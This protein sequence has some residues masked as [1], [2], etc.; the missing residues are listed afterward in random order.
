[1]IQVELLP[2]NKPKYS[3]VQECRTEAKKIRVEMSMERAKVQQQ[4]DQAVLAYENSQETMHDTQ[5]KA[6]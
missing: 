1:M 4:I 3:C 5:G 6:A 2:G